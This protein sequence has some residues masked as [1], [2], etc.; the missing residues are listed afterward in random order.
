MPSSF[1]GLSIAYDARGAGEPALVF[2]HGLAGSHADFKAQMD[3]FEETHRVVG[4][5]LPGYGDSDWDRFPWSFAAYGEDVASLVSSLD[6]ERVILIGHSFGGDV[7]LEAALRLGPL[8]QG[9]FLLSSLFK[10][11]DAVDGEQVEAY[12]APFRSDF[13]TAA[14]ALARRNA[15][16]HANSALVHRL[17]ERIKGADPDLTVA[18]LTAKLVNGP[19]AIDA[20]SQIEAPVVA[21]NPDFKASDATS[22]NAHGVELQVIAEAGHYLPLENPEIVNQALKT[23]LD[24]MTQRA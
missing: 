19:A 13:A 8:V 6:L 17:V 12:M 18:I 20:L 7:T 15:G 23:V 3:H 24:G 4:L 21:I 11:G 1:D 16:P 9:I 22:L 5:D 14:E 10:L 2:I